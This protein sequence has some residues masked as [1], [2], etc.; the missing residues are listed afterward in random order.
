MRTTR[1]KPAKIFALFA[2]FFALAVLG[3]THASTTDGTINSTY[4]YAWS[5]NGGW[6]NFGNSYGNINITDSGITGYIW[7]ENYGWINMSPTYGGVSVNSS[8]ALSGY[9]W[10]ENTGWVNF[11]GVSINCS[12]QF[13]GTATNDTLGTITFNCT[14]CKVITDYLPQTCRSS[15]SCG[16]GTCNGTETCDTCETDCGQCT[17]HGVEYC[18]NGFCAPTETCSTCPS[19]CGACA[20][21]CGDGTCNVNETCTTCPSDCGACAPTCG[22]NQCNGGENCNTCPSDCG[23]CAPICGDNQCN[24][25]ETCETCPNDCGTCNVSCGNGTCDP[26]ETCSTC[27]DDCGTCP[28]RCGDGAC[29][30]NEN[31]STCPSDCGVCAP[32]CGDNQCNGNETCE[33]CPFDCGNCIT[34]PPASCGDRVCSENETCDNCPFD[35]GN[36]IT[37]PPASCG[38]GA[39]SENETCNN[40]PADCGNCHKP[41][42]IPPIIPPDIRKIIETPIGSVATKVISTTGIATTVA[43]IAFASPLSL[44][45]LLLLPTRLIGLIL[46]AF[47]WKRRNPPWGIVYDSITKQ[48]LDPGYVTLKDSGG[49]EVSSAIT[50]LDGRYGFLVEPGFYRITAKKTNYLFPSQKLAGKT[51]D[52]L[53]NNL[54]FGEQIEIKRGEVITRNIPM[55]PVNFDWNEFTK[56]NKKLTKFY[57][58]WDSFLR[59][60]SDIIFAVGFIV[61]IIAFFSAPYPYNTII[62]VTYLLLTLLR[63]LGLKPKSFGY[64]VDG[65]SGA[66]LAFAILRIVDPQLSNVEM[67]HRITDKYGRYFCLV[68]KGRYCIKIERKNDDGSYSIA[69]TSAV[70]DTSKNGIIK[71]K[72]K[73]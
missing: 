47:G 30:P 23:A 60:V 34:P 3:Y 52:E 7:N 31:C 73:V 22:D 26:N 62:I 57:S 66:P 45:E 19:D 25:N 65:I 24:G 8:G 20:A 42:I 50:D 13:T 49:K 51:S 72:F 43:V 59:Q 33:T 27:A 41:P 11:T 61:A 6:L 9:G 4:K 37:P 54:Y 1:E 29:D 17:P 32:I 15:T 2:I 63:V 48:P 12:G 14:N 39:C 68:P 44:P 18:G 53:Y 28:S 69:Y 71:N 58:H 35:C 36:C 10:G 64:V 38:D 21:T 46:I 67:G 40:C 56:R 16:D 55:D 5:N 70:I